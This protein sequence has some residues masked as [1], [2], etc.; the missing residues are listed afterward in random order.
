MK[1][2]DHSELAMK[3]AKRMPRSRQK[4]KNGRI[5]CQHLLEMLADE[6]TAAKP[7]SRHGHGRD[8]ST[9]GRYWVSPMHIEVARSHDKQFSLLF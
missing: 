9:L 1:I 4:E 6:S 2:K 8:Q 7:G 3:A 5:I